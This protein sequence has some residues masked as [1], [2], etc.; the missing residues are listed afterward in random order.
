MRGALGADGRRVRGS[1]FTQR[2]SWRGSGSPPWDWGC[3][4]LTEQE[5]HF[6]LRLSLVSVC[7]PCQK[8]EINRMSS[9]VPLPEDGRMRG[10]LVFTRLAR[11]AAQ[12]WGGALLRAGRERPGLP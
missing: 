6:R 2:S 12:G 8:P 5:R 9:A 10:R 3:L 1:C 11:P 4:L 7:G